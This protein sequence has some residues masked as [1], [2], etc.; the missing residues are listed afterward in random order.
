[1]SSKRLPNDKNGLTRYTPPGSI[2]LIASLGLGLAIY[3]T[4]KHF[5]LLR[6]G[7]SS[8]S[9]CRPGSLFD[10]N[11]VETSLYSKLF[12]IPISTLGISF[13]L[14]ILTAFF[15]AR[16]SSLKE[17]GRFLYLI[18][19]LSLL[20]LFYDLFLLGIMIF[21][22]KTLCLF[23]IATYLIN[24]GLL[25]TSSRSARNF[26]KGD[27]KPL[28]PL[29]LTQV[30]FLIVTVLTT[31]LIIFSSLHKSNEMRAKMDGE[32]RRYLHQFPHLPVV[33]LD[34]SGQPVKGGTHPTVT[35]VEF[36]D[37]LCPYCR[38]ASKYFDVLL[39][40]FPDSLQIV[41][42]N[43][44]L[45]NQCNA[46]VEHNFHEG[47]CRLAAASECAHLQGMFWPL[48]DRIFEKG[49]HYPIEELFSDAE[50]VGLNMEAFKTCLESEGM[51]RVQEDVSKGI[52]LKIQGTP[53]LFINGRPLPGLLPL[54]MMSE[55]IQ[56]VKSMD[57]PR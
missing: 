5:E 43:F 45:E 49:P 14:V 42:R 17:K 55:L 32:L 13:Y 31:I 41:Y 15:F 4:V 16:F 39:R 10:C 57:L 3:L 2:P 27:L 56:R 22:L 18:F 11:I 54:E 48:H 52:E 34:T 44:P 30:S 6:G 1:M 12:G 36:S 38:L 28:L 53:S 37:F 50:A 40:N 26:K 35:I 20:A 51:L 21:N 33:E 7:L 25:F 47:S 46:S 9:F 24:L 23:C 29:S 19:V 8:S